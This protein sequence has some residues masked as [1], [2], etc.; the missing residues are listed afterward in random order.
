MVE[1]KALLHVHSATG[2][3]HGAE[4][5]RRGTTAEAWHRAVA[6]I[7][8][9]PFRPPSPRSPRARQPAAPFAYSCT[10]SSGAGGRAL[11]V[12]GEPTIGTPFIESASAYCPR[13][14]MRYV[15]RYVPSSRSSMCTR[16]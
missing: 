5:C 11:I 10:G 13:F 9:A 4:S 15:Q 16:T 6:R 1:D 8:E 14:V 12:K 7:V 3:L 2:D